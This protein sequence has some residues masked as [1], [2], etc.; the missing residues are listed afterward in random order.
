MRRALLLIA[1]LALAGCKPEAEEPEPV[2]PVL[3][4]EAK[5]RTQETFGPFAGS[6]SCG[7]LAPAPVRAAAPD[8]VVRHEECGRILIRTADS[9]I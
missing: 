2:R 5:V 7:G 1:L 6:I 9:G 8:E 3:T 4:V